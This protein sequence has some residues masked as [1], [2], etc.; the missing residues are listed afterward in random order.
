[1]DRETKGG[2]VYILADRFRGALYVGV[3]SDLAARMVQHRDGNGSAYC[4]RRGI[5]LLVWAERGD[6]IEDCIEHEKGLKRW[7]R[8][9]KFDLI[10]KT[11]PDWDDLFEHLT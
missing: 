10:E 11:N 7:R 3:T 9:W 6:S 8:E 1:M 2:W 5:T 4:A